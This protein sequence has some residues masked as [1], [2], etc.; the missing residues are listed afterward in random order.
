[1]VKY[2]GALLLVMAFVTPALAQDYPQMELTFGYGNINVKDLV[3]GRHSG[4]VTYQT[5][6][7]TS[8]I[9]LENYLG[10]FGLGT[11]PNVGK[12]ELITDT[13]G[14]RFNIRTPGPVIYGSAGLGIGFLRFPQL[15]AGSNN[16][17]AFK[18]GGGVDVPLN[19]SFS[20]KGEVSRMSFHMSDNI[21]SW[22]SGTNI[23][24]GIVFKMGGF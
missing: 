2:V 22:K 17:M 6:N 1:M 13:F 10:Y 20:V 18:V 19:E 4:F 24:A 5:F 7:L 23:T 21:S 12:I 9:A 16:S 8:K 15:G 3:P 14:G 11:D